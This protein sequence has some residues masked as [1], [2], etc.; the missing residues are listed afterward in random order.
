MASR[1]DVLFLSLQYFAEGAAAD[2][3]AYEAGTAGVNEVDNAE[4]T[5]GYDND[6]FYGADEQT[7]NKEGVTEEQAQTPKAEV[8]E[9][10]DDLIGKN[11]RFRSEYEARTQ[12][13]VQERL[14]SSKDAEKKLSQAQKM[15]DLL[16]VRYGVDRNDITALSEAISK[17]NDLLEAKALENGMNVET[18]RKYIGAQNESRRLQQELSD[19]EANDRSIQIQNRWQSEAEDL[20]KDYP[21]F[22]LQAEIASNQK[23]TDLITKGISIA[24]AYRLTHFDDIVSDVRN[25]TASQ[26][27]Q[28]TVNDIRAKGLRPHE[29]DGKQSTPL[30][31]KKSVSELSDADIEEI[32]RL[33]RKGVSISF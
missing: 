6:L 33:T 2:G 29:S 31:V 24:D 20:S 16:S 17:D 7:E 3:A 1:N 11:G 25:K 30:R 10:F 21:D 27:K 28:A 9:S 14:K 26:A 22:N 13:I 4:S 19:K 12:K 15:F 23:F 8:E 5:N 32:Q 18:Y